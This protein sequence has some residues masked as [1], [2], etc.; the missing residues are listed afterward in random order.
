MLTVRPTDNVASPQ[1]LRSQPVLERPEELPQRG[2]VQP[3]LADGFLKR[4]LPGYRGALLH[5]FATKIGNAELYLFHTQQKARK[6]FDY[7]QS[8]PGRET[9]S[10]LLGVVGVNENRGFLASLRHDCWHNGKT[11]ENRS[12]GRTGTGEKI[13]TRNEPPRFHA[14]AMLISLPLAIVRTSEAFERDPY[15]RFLVLRG[16]T[17]VPNNIPKLITLLSYYGGAQGSLFIQA[18]RITAMLRLIRSSE[19]LACE[20]FFVSL[21]II[22]GLFFIGYSL[23]IFVE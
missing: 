14:A 1:V 7:K 2:G 8:I 16:I 9:R 22:P 15:P 21:S 6:S 3:A 18:L 10:E 20:R 23:S 4:F 12:P 13:K 19:A 5:D 11:V 17:L